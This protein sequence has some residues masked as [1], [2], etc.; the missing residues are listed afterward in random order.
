MGTIII[1]VVAVRDFH[2][3]TEIPFDRQKVRQN[4]FKNKYLTFIDCV[5][6]I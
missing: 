5:L 6:N 2:V 3:Y 1:F 4:K